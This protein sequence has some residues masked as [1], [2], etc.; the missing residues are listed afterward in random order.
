MTL[1]L[2]HINFVYLMNT[3][4]DQKDDDEDL[5]LPKWGI[6][7]VFFVSVLFSWFLENYFG[8]PCRNYL[9]APKK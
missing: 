5:V 9:R 3:I 7:V 8:I 1:Y 2:S 4:L 6:P